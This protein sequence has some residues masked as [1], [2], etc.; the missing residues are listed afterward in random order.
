MKVGVP[1]RIVAVVAKLAMAVSITTWHKYEGGQFRLSNG[2]RWDLPTSTYD[3]KPLST[4][5]ISEKQR[6]LNGLPGDSVLFKHTFAEPIENP[7]L[8]K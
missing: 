2:P 3:C 6:Y 7:T 4:V 1:H 5:S 8:V